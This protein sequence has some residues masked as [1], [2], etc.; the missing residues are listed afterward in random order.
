MDKKLVLVERRD[1]IGIISINNPEKKNA[2]NNEML[3]IIDNTLRQMEKEKIRGIIITATGN[4][5]FCSG[6][7]VTSFPGDVSNLSVE[8]AMEKMEKTDYLKL[9]SRTIEN[10]GVPTIA[11][12]N[13]HCIGAGFDIAGACDFR[14][15]AAGIKISVPPAKLGIVYNPEGIRRAINIMGLARAKELFLLGEPITA[16]EAYEFGFLNKVLPKEDLEEF[17]MGI[18]NTLAQNAPLSI[19]G[20]KKIFQ[21]CLEHQE[22]SRERKL[23][24][25]RLILKAMR[26][27]DASEAL[28]AFLEK[29]RPVFKGR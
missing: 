27:E 10:I 4:K 24:S 29:R 20:M 9:T 21:F 26:S 28:K 7:D 22:L 1:K 19:K 25:T 14:Y 23:D 8:E 15:G 2:V 12:I 6:Y 11:M 16:E 13:G 17:T 18:A 5:V 3:K